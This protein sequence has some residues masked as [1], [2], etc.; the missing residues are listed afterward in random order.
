MR[1]IIGFSRRNIGKELYVML[2]IFLKCLGYDIVF[3]KE[4]YGRDEWKM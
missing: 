2:L 4:V 3:Y 1:D